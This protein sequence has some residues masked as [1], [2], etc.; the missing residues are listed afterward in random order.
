MTTRNSVPRL[1]LASLLAAP[2]FS[3]SALWSESGAGGGDR[4]GL[5]VSSLGDVNGDGVPDVLVGAPNDDFAGS[6]AG[7]IFALSGVDGAELWRANGSSPGA[8]MGFACA[9][10]GDVDG[11]GVGDALG[12][13]RFGDT[14]GPNFGEATVVSGATG[15]VLYTFFGENTNGR[16]GEAVGPAGDVNGDG[17]ADLI[18]GARLDDTSGATTGRARVYSGIDGA[19]LYSIPGDHASDFFGRAVGTAGDINGD[20]L[21][22]FVV[23]APG[24]DDAGN[25]SGAVRVFSGADGTELRRFDGDSSGDQ[26]GGKVA[27]AGD[28]NQDGVQDLIAGMTTSDF[29]GTD[30][31]AAR[32][33]SGADGSTL[34]TFAGTSLGGEFGSAVSG[35]GDVNGDGW[36]DLSV[37]A[38]LDDDMGQQVGSI[39]LFSGFDG[40][41]LY[42]AM[43]DG[44][45]SQFGDT[46]V[47]T[48]DVNGDGFAD[49]F[50]GA[51][52]DSGT[53]KSFM[54]S[55]RDTIG[56][57]ICGPAVV[58][59]SGS[60]ARVIA[61]GSS[62]ATDND[63]TL[64]VTQ[65]PVGQFGIFVTSLEENLILNP[66]GS[67]GHLC[68]ASFGIGRYGSD[69][70][71]ADAAG[72]VELG[73]DLSAVPLPTGTQIVMA[74]DTRY[75][76]FWFR[77]GGSSNFSDA[78]AIDFN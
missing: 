63:L 6:D 53:G 22:D 67:D 33:Y 44:D 78:I 40:S 28:I 29:G 75:W 54:L 77:D 43:G 13:A 30:R 20:M 69:V 8:S 71:Q 70:L 56:D 59:S 12:G 16:F 73:I 68:I 66:G 18:V 72:A 9:G 3:Q 24:D 38:R 55:G 74:G 45:L 26:L 58:N 57:T 5:C 23:C 34:Y 46:G 62:V 21:D 48:P 60:S 65:L 2:A 35:A 39:S 31:G 17:R 61:E 50:V 1:A 36:P 37:G 10:V 76:Q 41:L 25:L 52:G 7:A 51:F 32:V 64:T 15:L 27:L 11:D 19:E 47:I 42:K 49:V 14:A 4:F